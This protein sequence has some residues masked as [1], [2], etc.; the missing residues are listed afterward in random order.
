MDEVV[1]V[2]RERTG[3]RE[4]GGEAKRRV[5]SEAASPGDGLGGLVVGE[6]RLRGG[7][8]ARVD[9]NDSRDGGGS[10]EKDGEEGDEKDTAAGG[11]W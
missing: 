7:G 1:D 9:E 8:D 11:G 4:K 10:D 3:G 2:G 6:M 5:E